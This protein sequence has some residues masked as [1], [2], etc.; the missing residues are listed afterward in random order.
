MIL[1]TF[2][3]AFQSYI[4]ILLLYKSLIIIYDRFCEKNKDEK[5]GWKLKTTMTT[6]SKPR[7]LQVNSV[8]EIITQ[9]KRLNKLY[10]RT[11]PYIILQ[12]TV[13]NTK[14]FQLTK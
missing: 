11:F 14:V 5:S 2:A 13:K 8:D 7:P 4:L 6:N 12:E 9:L 1:N 3:I 10:R